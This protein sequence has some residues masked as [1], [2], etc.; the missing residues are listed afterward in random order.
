[1][2]KTQQKEITKLAHIG[3]DESMLHRIADQYS[4]HGEDL[5]GLLTGHSHLWDDRVVRE[6]FQSAILKDVRTTVITP[7][8]VIL[9]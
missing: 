7:V 1:M 6:A 9:R 2:V 4:R 8:S 5:D 3:I